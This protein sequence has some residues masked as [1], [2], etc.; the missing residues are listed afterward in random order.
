MEERLALGADRNP[1]RSGASLLLGVARSLL[2]FL[3]SWSAMHACLTKC[4]VARCRHRCDL[5]ARGHHPF[6]PQP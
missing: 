3:D 1:P 5:V 2:D 6:P 4:T